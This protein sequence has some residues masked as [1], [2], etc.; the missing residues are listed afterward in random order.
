MAKLG[1]LAVRSLAYFTTLSLIAVFIGLGYA[2][3]IQP[4]VGVSLKGSNTNS[5]T[6]KAE[7]LSL[8]GQLHHTIP[9]SF[10]KAAADNQTLQVVFCATFF[11]FG[12]L[13]CKK[14]RMK[15]TMLDFMESLSIIMFNIT[16]IVMKIVPLAIGGALAHTIAENGLI[17]LFIHHFKL[18]IYYSLSRYW[19]TG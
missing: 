10:F 13:V 4:G 1:R 7:P 11:S 6:D 3:L 9:T 2:N 19:G 18:F 17:Y 8:G 14:E 5:S 15:R 16:E 12:I